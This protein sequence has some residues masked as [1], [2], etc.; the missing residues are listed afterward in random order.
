MK[1]IFYHIV[2]CIVVA[3]SFMPG[4]GIAELHKIPMLSIHYNQHKQEAGNQQLSF[5][6]FLTMHYGDKSSHKQEEN[7]DDLPLFHSCCATFLFISE[8]TEPVL[9]LDTEQPLLLTSE[10]KNEYTYRLHLTIFQP[11]L[12]V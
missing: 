5:S 9:F 6:H 4:Q 2:I 3:A 12:W 8:K 10:V 11:P 1:R 7:H